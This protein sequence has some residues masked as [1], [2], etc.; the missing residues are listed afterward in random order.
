MTPTEL[1]NLVAPL[2]AARPECRPHHNCYPMTLVGDG[3]RYGDMDNDQWFPCDDDE[4]TERIEWHV[5]R[6]LD[7]VAKKHKTFWTCFFASA[8][9]QYQ[10]LMDGLLGVAAQ[11][12]HDRLT[13]KVKLAKKLLGIEDKP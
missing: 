3:W 13:A 2:W 7:D 11:Y 1:H 8:I 5:D 9:G 10:L 4:A 6:L 12:D